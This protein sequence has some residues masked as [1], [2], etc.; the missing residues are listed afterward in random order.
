MFTIQPERRQWSMWPFK[1]KRSSA[2]VP[3]AQVAIRNSYQLLSEAEADRW[4]TISL[5]DIMRWHLNLGEAVKLANADE[6]Y[7]KAIQQIGIS[8]LA[9]EVFRKAGWVRLPNHE[10]F[11]VA[12]L[13]LRQQGDLQATQDI[14]REAANQGW[15]G[16][17]ESIL[18]PD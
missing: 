6:R 2:P 15:A 4:V 5:P 14:C 17:W 12:A 7:A 13:H 8:A 16:D 1:R 11:R 3:S 9:A 10:G 18:K